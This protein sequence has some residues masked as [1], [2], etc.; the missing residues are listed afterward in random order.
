[1]RKNLLLFALLLCFIHANAS[2]IAA[3]EI[4]AQL[5]GGN[6]YVVTL[7]IYSE[8]Q[9]ISMAINTDFAVRDTN[10]F[11][12]GNIYPNPVNS[13]IFLSLSVEKETKISILILDILGNKVWFMPENIFESGNHLISGEVNLPNGQYIAQIYKDGAVFKTQKIFVSR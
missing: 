9:S 11:A 12:I 3:G 5:S 8:T 1:M 10:I 7:K 13:M 2:H 6:N 4:T